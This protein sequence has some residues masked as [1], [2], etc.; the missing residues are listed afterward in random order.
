MHHNFQDFVVTVC[1]ENMDLSHYLGK[2]SC[3]SCRFPKMS[4]SDKKNQAINISLGI[5]TVKQHKV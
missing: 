2:I 3:F 5:N 1:Q 4:I